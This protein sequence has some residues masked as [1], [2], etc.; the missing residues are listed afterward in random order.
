MRS[1]YSEDS[2]QPPCVLI[3]RRAQS[4]ADRLICAVSIKIALIYYNYQSIIID[5]ACDEAS[6]QQSK[7]E[8]SNEP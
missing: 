7:R 1:F 5:S 3:W 4:R 8:N 6:Q 2:R